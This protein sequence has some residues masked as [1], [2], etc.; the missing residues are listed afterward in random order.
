MHTKSVVIR[1][2]ICQP[3]IRRVVRPDFSRQFLGFE[4]TLLQR[5]LVSTCHCVCDAVL[6]YKTFQYNGI[7]S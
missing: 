5:L 3:T 7:L 4:N 6:D 2:S 1:L